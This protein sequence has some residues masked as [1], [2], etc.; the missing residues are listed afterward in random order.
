MSS[1]DKT[2]LGDRMKSYEEP[3]TSRRAF[4]GQPIIARLDGKSFHTFTK[5]LNRPYDEGLTKLMIE[6]M[7]ALVDK[8]QPLIG[9][10]QSDEITLAWYESADSQSEYPF[11]GRFQKLESVLASF[12][13][14]FFNKE[15]QFHLPPA[16]QGRLPVF[17]CRAF[18]VP[19][20]QEAYHCFLWR[21]QDATKNAVSMAAQS[22]YSHKELQHK[23]SD[24]MQELLFQKGINF[25]D[26]PFSFKRGTFAKRTRELRAMS[27][28]DFAR[29]PSQHWPASGLIERS[30][31]S[32]LDI[33]LS[34]QD[35]GVGVLFGDAPIKQV[36]G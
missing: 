9:Y 19:N 21:Q 36:A 28:A 26:Y 2:T 5:G 1:T 32:T 3:S 20:L 11:N 16:Y 14:V 7:K 22:C 27:P 4:K 33:W 35:D 23:H 17:D 12:A 29:I 8:F 13:S 34:K 30:V 10:T 31:I 15:L 24:Q 6:T 25:N 18:V